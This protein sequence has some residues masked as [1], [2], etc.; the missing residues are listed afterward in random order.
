MAAVVASRLAKTIREEFKIKLTQV[1]LWSDSMIVLAWLRSESTM[2]KSIVGVRVAEIQASF[3]T[4]SWRYVP[5]SLNPANDLSRGITVDEMKMNG[6]SF[7]RNEPE[8]WPTETNEASP[9]IAEM[10]TNKPLFVLQPSK[11]STIIDPS[12]YLNW[13]KLCG[14]L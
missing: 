2:L 7:L 6:P 10:K 4:T 8:E 14:Y 1:V 13:P 3:K 5:S 9:E 12:R 11:P